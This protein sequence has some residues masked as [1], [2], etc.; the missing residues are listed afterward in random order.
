MNRKTV[1]YSLWSIL[2][3]FVIPLTTVSCRSQ[4]DQTQT[5]SNT[6]SVS[7]RDNGTAVD[8]PKGDSQQI[9]DVK[10]TVMDIESLGKE[11]VSFG[12]KQSAEHEWMAIA[13]QIQ[14]LKPQSVKAEK[15][16]QT[17]VLK[18]SA[19]K[20]YNEDIFLSIECKD[21]DIEQM[22]LSQDSVTY[23]YVFDAPNNPKDLYW[24]NQSPNTTKQFR[25]LMY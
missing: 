18:D 20:Q 19:G 9:G 8:I 17:L 4:A 23:C 3:F 1:F 11:T 22:I 16:S 14:N 10:I 6:E 2:F 13:V 24:E 15:L 7:G 12:E 21:V 25:F 5:S